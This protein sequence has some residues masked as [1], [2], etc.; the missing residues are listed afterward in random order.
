MLDITSLTAASAATSTDFFTAKS[1]GTF[2]GAA[3]AT[4]IAANTIRFVIRKDVVV[5][6]FLCALLFSWVQ[7]TT[8]GH[9]D[10]LGGYA[11]IFL[12]GC[13]LFCTALGAN[14][15]LVSVVH[16]QETTRLKPQGRE[17]PPWFSGWV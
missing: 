12:N 3:T 2:A 14:Q 8:I 9:P 6:P 1:L 4:I 7:A 15:A 16:P 10:T 17:K 11:L 5:I 13:L